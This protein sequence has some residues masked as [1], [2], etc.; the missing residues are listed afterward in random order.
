M[1]VEAGSWLVNLELSFFEII[2][3]IIFSARKI[4]F[5]KR[6]L[7]GLLLYSGRSHYDVRGRYHAAT[8]MAAKSERPCGMT[9]DLRSISPNEDSSGSC[10]R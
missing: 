2:C 6:R 8:N 10:G 3:V 7:Q 1:G 4:F 9:L 5:D